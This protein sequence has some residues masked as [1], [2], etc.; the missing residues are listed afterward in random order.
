MKNLAAKNCSK[1]MIYRVV[2]LCIIVNI[3]EKQKVM[4]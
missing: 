3:Y 2:S 1:Y 4:N